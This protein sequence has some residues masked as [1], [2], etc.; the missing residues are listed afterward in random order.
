MLEIID[1][2][3]KDLA[4]SGG[5]SQSFEGPTVLK[6]PYKIQELASSTLEL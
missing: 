6:S 5:M 3:G 4:G 1:Q 2:L